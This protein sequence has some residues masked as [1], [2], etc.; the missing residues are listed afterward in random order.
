MRKSVSKIILTVMLAVFA[1]MFALS[2]CSQD[3]VTVT[4]DQ[5]TLTLN[6]GDSYTLEASASDGSPVAWTTSDMKVATVNA[7]GKVVARSAGEATITATS[8]EGSATCAVTVVR[9]EVAD[10]HVLRCGL[11][12]SLCHTGD[13]IRLNPVF[14]DGDTNL[15]GLVKIEY[16]TSD[17]GVAAVKDG[18]LE[19]K[20]PGAAKIT[21]ACTFDGKSYLD[22]KTVTVEDAE[23]A[24]RLAK[25]DGTYF[26]R[27]VMLENGKP[28]ADQIIVKYFGGEGIE[29]YSLTY[30]HEE[31]GQSVFTFGTDGALKISAVQTAEEGQ[32]AKNVL[33]EGNVS[34]AEASAT[35]VPA[36]ITSLE[37]SVGG[38]TYD[39]LLGGID[40]A[41]IKDPG[42]YTQ[43]IEMTDE[44]LEDYFTFT[45]IQAGAA[46]N[47]D[48]TV[49]Y[50]GNPSL[51]LSTPANISYFRFTD[52][53]NKA[54][55]Y[56]IGVGSKITM[57]IRYDGAPR[58]KS[59]YYYAIGRIVTK[60]GQSDIS[61]TS[62]VCSYTESAQKIAALAQKTGDYTEDPSEWKQITFTLG[63][64]SFPLVD[65]GFKISSNS[66]SS[67]RYLYI[68]E[69]T[70]DNDKLDYTVNFA[71][72]VTWAQ[73][74]VNKSNTSW[75]GFAPQTDK[76]ETAPLPAELAQSYR[77]AFDQQAPKAKAFSVAPDM[78]VSDP[79]R[80]CLSNINCEV[81]RAFLKGVKANNATQF[82]IRLYVQ[83][84]GSA[85]PSDTSITTMLFT[86]K[87]NN[88]TQ[89]NTPFNF[90]Q[91][92][93][94]TVQAGQWTELTF[95]IPAWDDLLQSTHF[96]V[97]F[98]VANYKKTTG[99]A[100]KIYIDTLCVV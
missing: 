66:A 34:C 54:E 25:P 47:I 79:A 53:I 44:M 80:S 35:T 22:E 23:Y 97:A 76:H 15:T 8:G 14:R 96:V 41:F 60:N 84:T 57:S 90:G 72:S 61:D 7:S 99:A 93:L 4:I 24:V 31:N 85:T 89:E 1:A 13:K 77:E 6:V 78:N 32:T 81:D 19:C 86:R 11:N 58:D 62:S 100:L 16:T 40:S 21:A 71:T 43:Y 73:A 51:K 83:S 36:K 91:D 29:E 87:W 74:G 46:M 95:D 70:I 2:G 26:D 94:Q 52:I 10:A 12:T 64:D 56:G 75:W 20:Q 69:I 17:E 98:N 45:G 48:R 82:K 65:L 9:P 3:K 30:G 63:E 67:E 88:A 27:S 59:L 68:G 39:D 37:A 28:L 92:K 5:T 49:T 38:K 18:Y 33:S 50:N 42:V 55:S